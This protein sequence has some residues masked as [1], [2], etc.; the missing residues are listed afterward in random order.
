MNPRRKAI[1]PCLH[2][3]SAPGVAPRG[4]CFPCYRQPGVRDLYPTRVVRP[5]HEPTALEIE[6][7][8]AEQL[9]RL[10]SWWDRASQE[11]AG[12]ARP[13]IRVVHDPRR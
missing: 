8:V 2:C 12:D 7:L 6:N 9:T 1:V 10:P 4:L 3:Q 5:D 11:Q 13:G